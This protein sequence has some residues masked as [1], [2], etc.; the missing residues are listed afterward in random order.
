[1]SS[2][3]STP[4]AS[5]T[6]TPKPT[7]SAATETETKAA[8]TPKNATKVVKYFNVY[9]STPNKLLNSTVAHSEKPC[10]SSDTLACVRQIRD[11]DWL[12]RTDPIT[13]TCRI[14]EAT[15]KLKSTVWLPRWVKPS[16][17]PSAL[18]SWWKKMVA[19][20][21]WHED[22]HIAIEKRYDKRLV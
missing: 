21:T 13:G 18:S 15:V 17:A 8:A 19:H 4:K 14:S 9:G 2:P 11:I 1:S 6:A 16:G 12:T 5:P 20:F 22:Q 10:G 3:T 7:T